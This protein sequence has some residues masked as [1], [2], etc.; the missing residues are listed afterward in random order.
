F[1]QAVEYYRTAL[2]GLEPADALGRVRLLYKT[3]DCLRRRGDL[4]GALLHLRAAHEALRPI[5]D[6]LCTGRLAGRFA[7][8]LTEK[9]EYRGAARY[10]HLASELLRRSS[11]HADLARAEVYLGLARLPLGNYLG[12]Q[13]A[14]T[15]A[16]TTFRRI[17]SPEGMAI[18]LNNLG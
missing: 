9:G 10:A 17:D 6:P 4:D 12:A 8:I 1:S 7:F 11:E 5:G 13:E 2:T 15:S 16:L 3:A 14:F 18:C